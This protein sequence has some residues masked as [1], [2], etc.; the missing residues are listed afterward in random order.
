MPPCCT[1]RGCVRGQRAGEREGVRLF[2]ELQVVLPSVQSCLDASDPGW[3]VQ[4]PQP[5]SGY[6]LLVLVASV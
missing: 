6:Q 2:L 3:H 4:E 5:S 1:A